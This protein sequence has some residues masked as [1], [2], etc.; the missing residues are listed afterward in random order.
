[1][2]LHQRRAN[3]HG[4]WVCFIKQRCVCVCAGAPPLLSIP[5]EN[6][7]RS[8]WYGVLPTS[9]EPVLITTRPDN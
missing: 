8:L 1:M 4:D 9:S 2:L 5:D 7:R 3:G 6:V